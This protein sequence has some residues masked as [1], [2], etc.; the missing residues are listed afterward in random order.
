LFITIFWSKISERCGCFYSILHVFVLKN[1]WGAS[2]FFLVLNSAIIFSRLASS[3]QEDIAASDDG[4]ND[5]KSSRN[6]DDDNDSLSFSRSWDS[7]TDSVF[8]IVDDGAVG[9][10]GVEDIDVVHVVDEV[11]VDVGGVVL[12][13]IEDG[14]GTEDGDRG[15]VGILVGGGVVDGEVGLVPSELD[16][17]R[18]IVLEHRVVRG[19]VGGL[20]QIEG[21]G[22]VGRRLGVAEVVI[23]NDDVEFSDLPV[24]GVHDGLHDGGVADP[25][26]EGDVLEVIGVGGGRVGGGPVGRE[27]HEVGIGGTLSDL[28]VGWLIHGVIDCIDFGFVVS[29]KEVHEGDD[30]DGVWVGDVPVLDLGLMRRRIEGVQDDGRSGC[31][32][33]VV[34]GGVG[35]E[36]EAAEEEGE[37]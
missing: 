17:E 21:E 22:E 33:D 6:G 28:P 30:V 12:S 31:D 35:A 3:P 19:A 24:G 32:S 29:F 15:I 27:V 11:V 26:H 5:D 13:H 9:E 1:V 23:D 36:G 14:S 2:A 4:R 16:I 37:G 18:L 20:V 7:N 8:G 25:V 34:G 10:V